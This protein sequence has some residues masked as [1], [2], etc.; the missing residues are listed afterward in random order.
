[1]LSGWAIDPSAKYCLGVDEVFPLSDHADYPDLVRF[2][3]EVAPKRVLTVHGY[4]AEFARDLRRLGFEARSLERDD[5]LE[6]NFH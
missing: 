6:F 3:E 1:M 4:T 5:Q 2:V